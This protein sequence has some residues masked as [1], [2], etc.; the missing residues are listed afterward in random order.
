MNE[1]TSQTP[2]EIALSAQKPID[3]QPRT[4][5]EVERI[6]TENQRRIVTVSDHQR[7]VDWLVTGE[8]IEKDADLSGERLETPNRPML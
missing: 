5:L 7:F 3:I 8:P 2:L 4:P 6:L 1:E